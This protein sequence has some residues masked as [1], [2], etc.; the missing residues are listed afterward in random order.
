MTPSYTDLAETVGRQ[1]ATTM[2]ERETDW[3]GPV[4]PDR[5]VFMVLMTVGLVAMRVILGALGVGYEAELKRDGYTGE[6]RETVPWMTLFGRVDVVSPYL[7]CAGKRAGARPM[8]DRLGVVGGGKSTAVERALTDFGID[9]SFGAA[10]AKFEEHYGATIHRTTVRRTVLRMA[11]RA[12]SF[13]EAKLATRTDE[14][15][16]QVMVQADG[17]LIPTVEVERVEGEK[18]PRG[19]PKFKKKCS[20]REVRLGL[21][22]P[23]DDD[24]TYVGQVGDIERFADAL[25]ATARHRGADDAFT[26]AVTDGGNGLEERIEEALD[27]DQHVLDKGHCRKHLCDTADEM[28]LAEPERTDQVRQWMDQLSRG[29]VDA[30]L[31]EQGTYA[32]DPTRPDALRDRARQLQA[33]LRRFR[34]SVHYDDFVDRGLI[35]GSGEIESAHRHVTQRRLKLAGAWW[36]EENIEPIVALRCVRANGWWD[37]FWRQAA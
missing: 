8:R 23:D 25:A 10:A 4:S 19:G 33:H 20:Y 1:I 7:R 34:D 35:I 14:R 37:D 2:L 22:V 31:A 36:A 15:P 6:R 9:E 24:P 30:V 28:G 26:Y 5:R 29:E 27:V 17:A 12:P 18:G 3:E 16:H 13:I 32:D 21:A 11:R